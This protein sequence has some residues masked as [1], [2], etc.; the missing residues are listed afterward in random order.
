M[1]SREKYPRDFNF[2]HIII[3]TEN[4][5]FILAIN[6][7]NDLLSAKIIVKNFG[8][9]ICKTDL[10]LKSFMRVHSDLQMLLLPGSDLVLSCISNDSCLKIS[11]LEPEIRKI[12]EFKFNIEEGKI[13]GK[14]VFWESQEELWRI[15]LALI[16]KEKLELYRMSFDLEE[17]KKE[18][19]MERSFQVSP[20]VESLNCFS[21]GIVGLFGTKKGL[22]VVNLS[23]GETVLRKRIKG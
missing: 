7:N 11:L 4:E 9:E 21:Q 20:G 5:F 12:S 15:K 22:Q 13:C 10:L 3:S 16:K 8:I 2:T 14:I 18:F 6:E 19:V 23:N 1:T 17:G